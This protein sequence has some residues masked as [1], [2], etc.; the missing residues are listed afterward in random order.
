M[1]VRKVK[2][3]GMSEA[4]AAV[5]VAGDRFLVC[6]DEAP[7]F[8]TYR[9]FQP[10]AAL[11]S[12]DFT[13]VLG[14]EEDK[15]A[16]IESVTHMNG[17]LVWTGSHARSKTGKNRPDWKRLFGT[18]HPAINA[19]VKLDGKAYRE[20]V[21]QFPKPL[22]DAAALAPNDGGLN[23]EALTGSDDGMRLLVGLRGPL[24]PSGKAI[25]LPV[26][27]PGP[28][29]AG[30]ADAVLGSP[31]ELALDG[32]GIRDIQYW[33]KKGVYLII[34]GGSVDG[35]P[36][37]LYAWREKEKPRRIL[38]LTNLMKEQEL[39]PNQA[40]PEAVLIHESSGIV[41]LLFDEGD[42]PD[43]ETNPFFTSLTLEHI[44]V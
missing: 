15:G 25:L 6:G 44:D 28:L 35:G 26:E 20:L 37:Q 11:H 18:S 39:N 1:N 29:L 31:I 40:S 34:G 43:S 12:Q 8:M 13:K 36:F 22:R 23:I 2:H 21:N 19:K 7:L 33:S 30:N 9:A 38:D 32:L 41:Q 5:V 14:L 17:R 27:N 42:R 3:T 24:S 10:G 16:D 4:S